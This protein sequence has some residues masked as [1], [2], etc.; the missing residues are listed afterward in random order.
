MH[1]DGSPPRRRSVGGPGRAR[2]YGGLGV[3][4]VSVSSAAV[5]IR[6]AAAPA[7]SVAAYRLGLAAL[8][9]APLGLITA[10]RQLRALTPRQWLAALA[11]AACLA[12]HF[13][14]WITSLGHTSVASSVIIVTANP[15]LV[16]LAAR[17]LLGERTPLGVMAGVALGLV[18]GGIIA[19]SDWDLGGGRL[20]GDA[21]ALLGAGAVTG[22]YIAGRSLREHLPLLGYVAP[23]Y[24]G[25]ALLLLLAAGLSGAPLSGFSSQTYGLLLLVAVVPQLLGHSSLNWALGYVRAVT[26]AVVVMSEPVGAT[27]LAWAVLGEAPGPL[28]LLGGL[29]ILSGVYLALRGQRA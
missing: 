13:G 14:F 1:P 6:L 8:V 17:P 29:F 26:V 2:L 21:M 3:G 4:A 5:L 24:G 27:L 9:V 18:G 7:L 16:A 28:V 10:H 25:A 19:L 20:F 15:I 12:L 23:V 11:S 22:Y